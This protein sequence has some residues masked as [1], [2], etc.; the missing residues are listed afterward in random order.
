MSGDTTDRIRRHLVE[1][2]MPRA[3]P[4][5]AGGHQPC[6]RVLPT[7]HHF[8][9]NQRLMKRIDVLNLAH[10]FAGM[11]LPRFDVHQATTYTRLSSHEAAFCVDR[12]CI[13]DG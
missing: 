1:L 6:Q 12:R 13:T 9:G 4:G 10:P 3:L 8:R 2:K 11:T 5:R 7:A